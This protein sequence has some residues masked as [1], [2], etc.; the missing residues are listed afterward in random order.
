MMEHSKDPEIYHYCF[1]RIFT[2]KHTNNH[3]VIIKIRS[4]EL[5]MIKQLEGDSYTYCLISAQPVFLD[6]QDLQD[7]II[8]GLAMDGE[9]LLKRFKAQ[10]RKNHSSLT[11]NESS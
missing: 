11:K 8:R 3:H 4:S 2:V 1:Y 6:E 5:D 9:S 7:V 10:Q